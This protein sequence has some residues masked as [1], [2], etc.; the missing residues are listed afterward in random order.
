MFG[1]LTIDGASIRAWRSRPAFWPAEL[2]FGDDFNQNIEK[3]A[4]PSGLQE[5]TFGDDFN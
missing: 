4:L 2:T 1:S 5:L 3:V